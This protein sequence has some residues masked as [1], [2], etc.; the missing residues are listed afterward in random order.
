MC[1]S[2]QS[3]F[4]KAEVKLL[5]WSDRISFGIPVIENISI[6]ELAT[7]SASITFNGTASGYFVL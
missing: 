4:I 1:N 6:R 3:S 7:V 2:L 5:P